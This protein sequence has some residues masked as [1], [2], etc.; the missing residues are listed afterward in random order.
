M[1]Y[2]VETKFNK[3]LIRQSTVLMDDGEIISTMAGNII[4]LEEQ[5]V[6][7]AL[8]KLGWTPPTEIKKGDK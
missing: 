7:D 5:G 3:E 6:R 4:R 8:I 1:E 2:T